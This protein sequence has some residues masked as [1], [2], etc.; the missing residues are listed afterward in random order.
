VAFSSMGRNF[1]TSSRPSSFTVLFR[2]AV[3]VIW[4]FPR[5]LPYS[6]PSTLLRA[7]AS[8]LT[9]FTA[10]YSNRTRP[11]T[12]TIIAVV[13]WV[14]IQ[15]RRTSSFA[16]E[17]PAASELATCFQSAP[18]KTGFRSSARAARP[19][20]NNTSSRVRISRS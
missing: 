13:L 6:I 1:C 2:V 18:G 20:S 5:Y 19:S 16:L 17:K 9:C 7:D 11:P 4:S 14:F 8:T 3:P 12:E 15:A 10:P